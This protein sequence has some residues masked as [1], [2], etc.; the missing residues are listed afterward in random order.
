MSRSRFLGLLVLP[1]LAAS[2]TAFPQDVASDFD[3]ALD[4]WERGRKQE[5]LDAM[6]RLLASDPDPGEVYRVYIDSDSQKIIDFMTEGDEYT[7]VAER[8]LERASLGRLDIQDDDDTIQGLVSE[9]FGASSTA[10]RRKTLSRI[11]AQHGEYACPRFVNIL[12]L[13]SD[14]DRVRDAMLA[15]QSISSRAVQPLI[16][17]LASENAYQRRNVAMTLGIIG[18]PRAGASLLA[19]ASTDSDD[20]VR[21]A[22]ATGAANCGAS[23]DAVAL[24]L[25]LGDDY[26]HRRANVLRDL[27][28]SDVV[29]D[30]DGGKLMARP[31]PRAV[32]NNELAKDAF[33]SALGL[34]PD[35]MDAAAGIARESV[36]IQGKLA[37]LES[38]GQDVS[39]MSDAA[40]E[41][42]L[43]VLAA[44]PDA[45]DRALQMSV[46]SGD[47]AT[48]AR[49]A[50]QLGHLA[51]RPTDGLQAA[52]VGGGASMA[53]EAAVALAHIAVS[54]NTSAST[55]V[56]NQLGKAAGRRVVKVALIIDGDA[57]RATD[58]VAA[59]DGQGVL[60]QHAGTGAQGLLALGQLSG[61]DV[62][63]VGDD[64]PDLTT[65]AVVARIRQ[66]PAY[67]ATPTFLLTADEDLAEAYG[68][69]IQGSF[70]GADG[71]DALQEVFDARLDDNRAR[72]DAL[73]ARAAMAISAL[74]ATGADVNLAMDG[75]MAAIDGRRDGIAIPA[76]AALG[77]AGT[78]GSVDGILAVLNNGDASDEVRI[79]AANA[80]G[81]IGGRLDLAEAVSNSVRDVLNGD[82]SLPLKSAAAAAL[83][84]MNLGSAARAGVLQGVR[85]DIGS[86]E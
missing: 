66:N 15:L 44:G 25:Q 83:G 48:G 19:L 32:Y 62:L 12:G 22:A 4:L 60:A 85:V 72:A 47:S 3:A 64:I 14:P 33:Y 2:A 69:R 42:M 53:G 84:R 57:Q 71:I 43:A 67:D 82:G 28:Y 45:L 52:L 18:D 78:A 61:I 10:D 55:E 5:A 30:W 37:A 75:L 36:D 23:G 35:S 24:F 65:D 73:A 31:V 54:T 77:K 76:L 81:A 34:A 40:A 17:A 51:T 49:I 27:D 9:Y 26:H 13:E 6:R 68:D 58:L 39:E 7:R 21:S 41:G 1:V 70:A 11:V 86:S 80:V 8:F 46:A 63:L 56:V 59:L 50:E 20:G 16:T 79:A 29:W 74:A 38:A